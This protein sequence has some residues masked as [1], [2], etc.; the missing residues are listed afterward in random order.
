MESLLMSPLP[1]NPME[2]QSLLNHLHKSMDPNSLT[3][4]DEEKVADDLEQLY[5][6]LITPDVARFLDGMEHEHK[7]VICPSQVMN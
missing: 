6:L 1:R 7:L 3:E 2:L 5:M 4:Y